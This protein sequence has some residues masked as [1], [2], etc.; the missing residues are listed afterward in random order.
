MSNEAGIN[1]HNGENA[2]TLASRYK[3]LD[4][5]KIY[6]RLYAHVDEAATE[7]KKLKILDIGSGSGD[8]AIEMARL[9]HDVL[10]I[11]PSD[12]RHIALRDHSHPQI[13]YRDG[14][15]PQLDCLKSEEKF[16]LVLLSAVW[17]YIDPAERVAS[18]LRIAEVMAPNAQ[19]VISY[20][21]P[22]SR[23]HQYEASPEMFKADIDDANAMLPKSKKLAIQGEPIILPDVNG[24][25]SLDGRELNFYTYTIQSGHAQ[26]LERTARVPG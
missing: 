3:S 15:L 2:E 11:E 23:E 16:D 19:L 24:R 7:G 17:Q 6:P 25:K 8:N 14:S 26:A 12:L 4:Q 10:A 18:L 13:E 22:P 9:G 21:S 5:R 20:P 1:D